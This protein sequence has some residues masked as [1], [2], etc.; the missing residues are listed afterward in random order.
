MTWVEHP[1]E[2]DTKRRCSREKREPSFASTISEKR[3]EEK[4][5][6]SPARTKQRV[7][8]D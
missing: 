7:G 3:E 2:D 4:I 5:Q 1:E 6:G 8:G